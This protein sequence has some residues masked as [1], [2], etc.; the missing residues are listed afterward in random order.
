MKVIATVLALVMLSSCGLFKSRPKTTDLEI[1]S[2]LFKP[3]LYPWD[4]VFRKSNFWKYFAF[5]GSEAV[6]EFQYLGDTLSKSGFDIRNNASGQTFSFYNFTE[7]KVYEQIAYERTKNTSN[8][9]L[10]ALSASEFD[11]LRYT[12]KVSMKLLHSRNGTQNLIWEFVKL[13]T[14]VV[15]NFNSENLKV[16]MI[17]LV[18]KSN[19]NTLKILNNQ[20]MPLVLEFGNSVGGAAY[21]LED[22]FLDDRL[23]QNPKIEIGTKLNYRIITPADETY[24]I[25]F[26]VLKLTSDS[27]VFDV[28]GKL[29]GVLPYPI[30]TV[31]T[32][33]FNSNGKDAYRTILPLSSN[34]PEKFDSLFMIFFPKNWN[35][36]YN[37]FSIQSMEQTVDTPNGSD[38]L[39]EKKT[40]CKLTPQMEYDNQAYNTYDEFTKKMVNF[41]ANLFY[42]DCGSWM[43]EPTANIPFL[44]K[45]SNEKGLD[46]EFQG[47][48]R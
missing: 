14:F 15:R 39:I 33:Y 47:F 24:L 13:D 7:A 5:D 42:G 10:L 29:T 43:V 9:Q 37:N 2:E 12:G 22:V 38:E 48:A 36:G 25:T 31:W 23:Y 6:I 8:L 45:Y 1:K 30:S 19:L 28:Q 4:K 40:N 11:S 3:S 35:K 17:E 26:K 27:A 16:P 18:C 32:F 41:R 20:S 46:V 21:K 34:V 44:L